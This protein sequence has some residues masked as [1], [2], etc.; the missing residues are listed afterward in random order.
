MKNIAAEFGR[1]SDDFLY[2]MELLMEYRFREI[3][4]LNWKN[5]IERGVRWKHQYYITENL[6][7]LARGGSPTE[8]I[9]LFSLIQESI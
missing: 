3:S 9:D 7:L 1:K 6:V 4:V 5:I 8:Q 2:A